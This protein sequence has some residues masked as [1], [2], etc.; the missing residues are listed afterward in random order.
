MPRQEDAADFYTQH[1]LASSSRSDYSVTRLMLIRQNPT[2]SSRP[3][4]GDDE[5]AG[6]V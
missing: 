2:R 4:S 5:H 1:G 3:P 6:D